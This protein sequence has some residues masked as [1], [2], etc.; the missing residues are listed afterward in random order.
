MDNHENDENSKIRPANPKDD[1]TADAD[2]PGVSGTGR[3]EENLGIHPM[4]RKI[5]PWVKGISH[6][7]WLRT[8]KIVTEPAAVQSSTGKAAGPVPTNR[9]LSLRSRSPAKPKRPGDQWDL[10]RLPP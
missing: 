3:W 1:G 5:G 9:R 8:R 6:D 2:K 10:Q 7:E 4:Q